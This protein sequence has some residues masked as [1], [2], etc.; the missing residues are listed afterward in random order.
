MLKLSNRLVSASPLMEKPRQN[1]DASVHRGSQLDG[2]WIVWIEQLL[3]QLRKNAPGE[4]GIAAAFRGGENGVL[5]GRRREVT[6]WNISQIG[7]VFTL[8]EFALLRSTQN[9]EFLLWNAI[10]HRD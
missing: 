5:H 7:P 4:T 6:P 9:I 1:L 2:K 10:R 3:A 8:R